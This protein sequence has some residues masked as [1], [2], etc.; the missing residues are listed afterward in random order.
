MNGITKIALKTKMAA[1]PLRAMIVALAIIAVLAISLIAEI[2][3]FAES[4][5]IAEITPMSEMAVF[6]GN[7][8]K[9]CNICYLLYLIQCFQ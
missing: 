2:R 4:Y 1:L 9:G 6:N 8:H 3:E 5:I 7:S